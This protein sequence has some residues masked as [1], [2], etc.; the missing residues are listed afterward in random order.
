[1]KDMNRR[2]FNKLLGASVVGVP[3]SGLIAQLPS[4]ADDLPMVDPEAAN[5]VAL[6]YT[7]ASEKDG[8]VCGSCSL[9]QGGDAEK[10]PCPLFPG[11]NVSA[12]GWCSAY[13]PK[14]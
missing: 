8:M 7:N 4:H 14:G 6:Q 1:M 3:L 13:V 5:A 9:F 2:K 12:L 11:A 10:G